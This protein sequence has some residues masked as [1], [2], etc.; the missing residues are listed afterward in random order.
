MCFF[1]HKWRCLMNLAALFFSQCFLR[2]GAWRWGALL[3]VEISRHALGNMQRGRLRDW[4]RGSGAIAGKKDW[5][6]LQ[7]L[8]QQVGQWGW[9]KPST[10][11]GALV[12]SGPLQDL[13]CWFHF[14]FSG[15]HWFHQQFRFHVW[16]ARPRPRKP[17]VIR[18]NLFQPVE[19]TAALR[20]LSVLIMI[21][22]L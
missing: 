12:I 9:S 2:P 18:Q 6:A 13:N 20:F 19:W 3:G 7:L 4:L 11:W 8:G 21:S 14:H 16:S 17:S 5:E 22:F 10:R 15:I 1:F